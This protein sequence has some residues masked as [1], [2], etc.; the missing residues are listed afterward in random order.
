MKGARSQ[1]RLEWLDGLRFLCA[2]EIV[3]FHWLRACLKAGLFSNSGAP[4]GFRSLVWAYRNSNTAWD[5][6]RYL[7]L[8]SHSGLAALL[9]N[10]V[11]LL[12]GFG[13]EAVEVFI[14]I[15][16]FSLSLSLG[17]WPQESGYWL[18]WYQRRLKRVLLPFYWVAGAFL[19]PF[20]S[21]RYGLSQFEVPPFDRIQAQV[22]ALVSTDSVNLL[23]SHSL[24]INP[25]AQQGRASFFAPAWWFVPAIV[26]AYL[27]FPWMFWVLKHKG[28]AVLLGATFLVS[29]IAYQLL[30]AGWLIENAWYDILLIEPCLFALGMVLGQKFRAAQQQ[31][32]QALLTPWALLVALLLVLLGNLLNW[33]TPTYPL[34]SL[35]FTPGLTIL[36]FRLAHLLQRLALF[37]HLSTVDSYHLYLIHQPFAYPVALGLGYLLGRYTTFFGALGFGI[38]TVWLTYLF[39]LAYHWGE[40]T[41]F[42]GN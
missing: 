1:T 17:N 13:W 21:L 25:W 7:L 8:D 42:P 15:S 14:L 23:V 27:A 16:G 37:R 19:I 30:Q 38:L 18:K 40:K 11:G 31:W 28:A 9:T 24:L 26:G 4:P 34:S 6:A 29:M 32:T 5:T 10:T 3:L 33:F 36:G 2:L 41:W 39:S 22:Q 35:V 12:G 20:L